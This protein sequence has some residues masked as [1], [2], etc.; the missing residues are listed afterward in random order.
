MQNPVAEIQWR[1]I[2]L[3]GKLGGEN[4]H[5]IGEVNLLAPGTELDMAWD[6]EQRVK[7]VL[8]FH[9]MKPELYLG[10]MR[11]NSNMHVC[12]LF[13]YFRW[14]LASDSRFGP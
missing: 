4:I 8:P 6:T 1:I 11:A 2:R 9:D 3:L 13:K 12:C 14:N 10:M 7:L 5:L